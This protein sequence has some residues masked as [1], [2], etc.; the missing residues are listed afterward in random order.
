MFRKTYFTFLLTASL[1]IAG[2]MTAFAQGT[3]PV[4]GKVEMTK[5]GV[6]VPV[7]DAT[8]DAFRTNGSGKLSTTTNKR[9]EFSYAGLIMGQ[10]YILAV[11]GPGL[12]P[13]VY[14]K[15]KG[16]MEGIVIEVTPGD[17]KVLTEAEAKS[18][19]VSAAP[20]KPGEMSAEDKKRLAEFEKEKQ[21]VEAENQDVTKKNEVAQRVF[22][23]GNVAFDAKDYDLAIAK[24]D[25]GIAAVPNYAGI[26]PVLL[27]Q[28]LAS[29]KNRGFNLYVE[30]AKNQDVQIRLAK[31]DAAKKEYGEALKSYDQAITIFKNAAPAP[32]ATE[33]KNR[34]AL[35]VK[36]MTN[37][38]EVHRLMAVSGVDA[39]R[40]AEAGVLF[41]E[42]IA[43]EPDPVKKSN[44]RKQLGDIYRGGGELDKAITAYKTVLETNPENMEVSAMV[45]L[46]LYMLG[47]T[48]EPANREM[49]QEGLNYMEKYAT[50]VQILATDSQFDKDFKQSVKDI[51]TNL[52][53]EQKLKPQA[54][55][56]PAPKRRG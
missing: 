54:P 17:G 55:A 6:K 1:F 42:Y 40:T 2:A 24:Y 34:A 29:L 32:D 41:E 3:G 10:E 36:L 37:A 43:Q 33:T 26:T 18:L 19:A 14:P 47:S 50:T 31:Y 38:M 46:C 52:K 8:I 45:G 35:G 53:E 11:S 21:K 12:R 23:E 20:G 16:N 30:G 5:D 27:N 48:T 49:L 7:A 25:E 15:V 13:S 9:G 51:V 56:K 4:R 28:K 22:K 44:A 39:T